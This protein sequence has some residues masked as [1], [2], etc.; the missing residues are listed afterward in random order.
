MD[1]SVK[2]AN[3]VLSLENSSQFVD[4]GATGHHDADDD[5]LK[6]CTLLQ[7]A[8]CGLIIELVYRTSGSADFTRGIEVNIILQYY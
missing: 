5:N 8:R 6:K 7:R 1:H 3:S 4:N 2:K